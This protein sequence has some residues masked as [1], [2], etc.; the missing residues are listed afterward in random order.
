MC[1][2]RS[3]DST[4]IRTVRGSV[5]LHASPTLHQV[6]RCERSASVERLQEGKLDRSSPCLHLPR[7]VL[8]FGFRSAGNFLF[9]TPNPNSLHLRYLLLF[10]FPVAIIITLHPCV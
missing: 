8:G 4:M 6:F 7:S 10:Y 5:Q 9:S 2:L 1:D 3:R